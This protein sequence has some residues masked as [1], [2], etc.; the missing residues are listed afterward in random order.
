MGDRQVQHGGIMCVLQT[1]FSSYP[2]KIPCQINY[3]LLLRKS[4]SCHRALD[5][6]VFDDNLRIIFLI[7]HRNH[8]L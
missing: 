3:Y 7:S 2:F 4:C 8:M 5:K 1:Q 6:R